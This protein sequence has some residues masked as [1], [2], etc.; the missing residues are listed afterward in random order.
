VS[1]LVLVFDL[2]DTLYPERQFALSGFAA[3]GRWA[4]A[5]LGVAGLAESMT[6][7]LDQ[8][9]LGGLFRIALS[10]GCPDHTP[11]HLA[12]LVD[13][14]RNHEPELT[15]FE[16]AAWALARFGGKA[17]LGLITDGTHSVQAKKVR[18]LGIAPHFG[19]IVYT[20]A[21]G[22]KEFSKPHPRGY[23]MVEQALGGA[24][25]RL[26]YV[27]DNP[28]KDFVAP[29]ARGW[30]SVMVKRTE[31]KRIHERAE[32]APG[33]APHHTIVSLT[34]LPRLLLQG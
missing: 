9:H 25:A 1:N 11:E 23:E 24:G 18:A 19:E 34:E 27:G 32:V 7:L 26:V 31:A 30:T 5:E 22:G 4:E 28:S 14:Y 6:H 15:L 3:A 10:D 13:A 17:K 33:G 29:N 2:D 20:H 16:D 12:A 8:G 21:L